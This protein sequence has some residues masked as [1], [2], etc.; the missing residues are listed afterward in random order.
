MNIKTQQQQQQTKHQV[1]NVVTILKEAFLY[2]FFTYYAN[3]ILWLIYNLCRNNCTSHIISPYSQYSADS[4]RNFHSTFQETHH[5]LLNYFK[6]SI[7]IVSPATNRK[8]I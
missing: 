8:K 6:L 7:N 1:G 4:Y 5:N 2:T 3:F